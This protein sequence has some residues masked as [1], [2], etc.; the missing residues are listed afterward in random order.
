M[1]NTTYTEENVRLEVT[2][3]HPFLKISYSNFFLPYESCWSDMSTHDN[4][5]WFFFLE[6]IL[7]FL[8]EAS[9]SSS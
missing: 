8:D 4:F 7:F 5:V 1:P 3:N 6:H 9:V 2:V